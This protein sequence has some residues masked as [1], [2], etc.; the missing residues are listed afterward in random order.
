MANESNLSGSHIR[1]ARERK[2][3]SIRDLADTPEIK[4]LPLT[5]DDL[6][7]I[8]AHEKAVCD[9]ELIALAKALGVS[10]TS[11]LFGKDSPK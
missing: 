10:G 4:A 11:L 5:G 3:M 1:D 2:G 8:E 6:V 7:Q 9:F